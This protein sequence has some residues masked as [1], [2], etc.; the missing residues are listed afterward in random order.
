VD[1]AREF[2]R[3]LLGDDFWG[4]GIE[5]GPLPTHAAARGAPSHWLGH[6]GVEDVV[7]AVYRFLD[8][9]ATLLGGRSGRD[10]ASR[11]V[12]RSN[13]IVRDPNGAL[14]AL[15]SAS[16]N[17]VDRV[18]WH[19]LSARDEAQAFGVYSNLFAWERV[20]TFDL[21]RDRG[22]H[23][24][25]TWKAGGAAVGSTSNI[26]RLPHVH[27]QWLFFFRVEN[28]AGSLAAVRELG[29]LTLPPT[30]TADGDLV[31]ACDDPQGA[32]FGLYQRRRH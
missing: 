4:R 3:G 22:R 11:V 14:V 18:E 29:G 21:G 19:L 9:G 16:P 27:A 7:G 13:A 20:E 30:E 32:A 2:Y 31:A 10:G 26:A 12:D 28:L 1:A 25:F 5:I 8:A 15:T 23:V 24:T 17:A 6:I